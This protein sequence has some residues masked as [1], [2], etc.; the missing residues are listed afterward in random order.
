MNSLNADTAQT[1]DDILGQV[2][3][4]MH[5]DY[6]SR[7]AYIPTEYIEP[8]THKSRSHRLK[9]PNQA[10]TFALKVVKG[11]GSNQGNYYIEVS[12][13][14]KDDYKLNRQALRQLLLQR[15]QEEIPEEHQDIF[16]LDDVYQK[17]PRVFTPALG[18]TRTVPLIAARFS[19]N[20]DEIKKLPLNE[21]FLVETIAEYILKPFMSLYRESSLFLEQ[22]QS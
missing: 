7:A 4:E 15:C 19:I 8:H 17:R 3:Q 6:E 2:M 16:S 18:K 22:T 9:F 5:N 10:I 13:N 21:D 20:H 14:I 1:L 11:R 12:R